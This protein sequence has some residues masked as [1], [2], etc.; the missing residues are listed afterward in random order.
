MLIIKIGGGQTININY[1]LEDLSSLQE[2]FIIIHGANYLMDEFCTK[3]N[4]PQKT[5]ESIS[6]FTSRYTDPE[7]M[8]IFIMVYAGL[9]NKRI[10]EKCHQYNINAVGLSGLDGKLATGQRKKA[11]KAKINKKIKLIKDDLSG[12]TE[13]INI[14]LLKLLLNNNY[15]PVICPPI[16]SEDNQAINTDNDTLT[17][18][19]CRDMDIKTIINLFEAPG[20]LKNP[21]DPNSLIL[22]INKNKINNYMKYGEGRMKKKLLGAEQAIKNNVTKIIL[23]DGRIKNPVSSALNGQGTIIQ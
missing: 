19:I 20:L 21:N 4:K 15:T 14:E 23:S 11:I 22:T 8:D 13:T 16:L 2:K 1:I 12:K 6:G 9:A 7:T 10:V 17:S 18:I 5:L 3:L